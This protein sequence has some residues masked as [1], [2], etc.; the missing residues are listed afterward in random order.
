MKRLLDHAYEFP[1]TYLH[2]GNFYAN[3]GK[4]EEAARLFEQDV[5]RIQKTN[6]FIKGN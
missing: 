5:P 6:S 2:A 3:L 1:Q 4:W